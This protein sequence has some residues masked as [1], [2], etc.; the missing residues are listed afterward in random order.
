MENFKDLISTRRS[1]RKY[2]DTK[3]EPEQVEL[4]LAA[5]LKSPTSKN[6]KPWEFLVVEDKDQL[7]NLSNLKKS[8]V[9]IISNSAISI[10]V[11]A[12]PLISD[13]CIEDASI[14]SMMM[15]L[16]AEDLGL[17]SCWIQV[18]GRQTEQGIDSEEY[19]KDLFEIPSY[20]M[21]LSVITIG[22]KAENKQ[23]RREDNLPWEKIHLGKYRQSE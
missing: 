16:Q 12:N 22:Y 4:I 2:T 3:L 23:P 9:K 15:Q 20:M 10:I 21:I 13:V 1:I 6:A 11:M 5:A 8:S 18:R 14:A 17:G 7:E 19:I